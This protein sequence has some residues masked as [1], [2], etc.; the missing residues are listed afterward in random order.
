[1]Y[2]TGILSYLNLKIHQWCSLGLMFCLWVDF[3]EVM[4]SSSVI[5]IYTR[6][7]EARRVEMGLLDCRAGEFMSQAAVQVFLF[8]TQ[9]FFCF[10]TIAPELNWVITWLKQQIE[11][12][13]FWAIF[14]IFQKD[15]GAG[16]WVA[17]QSENERGRI[18]TRDLAV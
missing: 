6:G 15:H 7:N 4:S 10:E 14:V 3:Q 11:D 12:I 17:L 9:S 1:M 2:R 5:T 16:S 13:A 18:W 8:L